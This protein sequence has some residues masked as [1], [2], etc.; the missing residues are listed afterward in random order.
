MNSE[1]PSSPSASA[2]ARAW[3]NCSGVRRTVTLRDAD[4]APFGGGP[5]EARPPR[6]PEEVPP[7]DPEERGDEGDEPRELVRGLRHAAAP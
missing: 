5:S 6:L 7:Y 3:K 2:R 4:V 1:T